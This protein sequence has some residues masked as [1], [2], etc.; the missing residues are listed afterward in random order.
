MAL[1][2]LLLA[3]RLKQ[4]ELNKPSSAYE[5]AQAYARAYEMYARSATAGA[6]PVV[7]T[8][9][10][11]IRMASVFMSVMANPR[12]GAIT[13]YANAWL[14][15]LVQ[16]WSVPPV[17]FGGGAVTTPPNGGIVPC[18][19]ANLAN[20]R[21]T[22]ESASTAMAQCIHVATLTTLVTIPPGTVVPV[23]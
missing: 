14:R 19:V 12:T 22:A 5:A 15:G 16:F 23:L 2:P 21:A 7:L 20:F 6:F 3:D 10:E 11:W 4:I 1:N 13:T 9:T 18:M 17:V 8:G